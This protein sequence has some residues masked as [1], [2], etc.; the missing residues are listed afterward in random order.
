M[1]H[2]LIDGISRRLERRIPMKI[3]MVGPRAVGKTTVLTAV[4]ANANSEIS[5]TTN[6]LI[7]PIGDTEKDLYNKKM[8]LSSIFQNR[9]NITDKPEAGI[10]ASSTINTFDFTFGLKGKQPRID[11]NIKDFPGEYVTTRPNEVTSFINESNAILIA[12]DTPHLMEYDGRYCEPKNHPADITTFFK[13][14]IS[15][16]S[17]EK[18]V[19]LVPLK[20]EKYWYERRG[21]EVLTRVEEA[22]KDLI[23]LLK[24]T[25]RI[26]CAV[27]PILTLGDVVY[28][29]MVEE[30]GI[31]KVDD[32]GCPVGV[33]YKFRTPKAE[34][35]PMFCAQPLYYTLSFLA[36]MYKRQRNK[37]NIIN[38]VLNSMLFGL[39]DKD[40]SL[41][42]EICAMEKN[43]VTVLQGFKVLCGSELFISNKM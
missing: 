18:L 12:I 15:Q 31:V 11:L 14:A 40:E 17:G 16:I 21:A 35:N 34:Y 22:Y 13:N 3:C 32:A 20:C 1:L 30:N 43:R 39:F 26:A 25:Q 4:F 29:H 10:A 38:K 37:A 24:G 33:E 42:D 5:T 41:Y 23:D 6:L 2:D 7:H 9:K 28:N 27:T 36:S 8:E 19:L